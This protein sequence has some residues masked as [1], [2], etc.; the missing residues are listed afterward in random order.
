[1][2][3]FFTCYFRKLPELVI[4][5]KT[6]LLATTE[7]GDVK[8]VDNILTVPTDEHIEYKFSFDTH[9]WVEHRGGVEV[10]DT[11]PPVL[12]SKELKVKNNLFFVLLT[13]PK[14]ANTLANYYRWAREVYCFPVVNRG[15]LWYD[16][17]TLAQVSELNEWYEKWLDVTHTF[18]IPEEPSW[19]NDKL[20]KLEPEE[21]L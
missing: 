1:M 9:K 15:K 3:E 17:L 19:I 8:I 10:K 4:G 11:K 6:I 5:N 2:K 20:E 12:M 14:P 7:F 16:H 18:A 21:L 13:S